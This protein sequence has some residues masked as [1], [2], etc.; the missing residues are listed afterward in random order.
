MTICVTYS[1]IYSYVIEELE[2][3]ETGGIRRVTQMSGILSARKKR[4]I[5]D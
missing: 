5:N 2:L 4:E 3:P 1:L